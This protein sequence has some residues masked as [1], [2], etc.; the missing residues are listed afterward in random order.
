[1]APDSKEATIKPV[2][3]LRTQAKIGA[4]RMQVRTPFYYIHT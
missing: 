4:S 1:M 2:T 3:L